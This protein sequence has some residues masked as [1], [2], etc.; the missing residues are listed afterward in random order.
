MLFLRILQ[1]LLPRAIAW[2]VTVAKTL[3]S[4]FEGLAQQ[5][6]A[7][8]TFLDLVWLDI[9]PSTTRSVNEWERHFGLPLSNESTDPDFVEARARLAAEWQ[10]TGGQSPAY[11]EGVLHAAGFTDLYVHEWWVSGPPYVARDPRDYTT[12]PRVGTYRCGSE[13]NPN[14]GDYVD[15]PTCT[16]GTGGPR[17]NNF[18]T[19]DPGYLVNKDLTQRPP[20]PVPD[21]PNTWPYF[22]Y[23]GGEVL[24]D[25]PVSVDP[26]RRDE[27]ERLLLKLRPTH[28]WIVLYASFAGESQTATVT[29]NTP[30]ELVATGSDNLYVPVTAE[31]FGFSTVI[32]G[33]NLAAGDNAEVVYSAPDPGGSDPVAHV[34]VTIASQ[35]YVDPTSV[36]VDMALAADAS[37]SGSSIGQPSAPGEVTA[38][39]VNP[40]VETV[41]VEYEFDVYSGDVVTFQPI[42]RAGGTYGG[43][44]ELRALTMIV[45]VVEL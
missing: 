6:A 34:T 35:W 36:T 37:G 23:I 16:D 39:L 11:I 45:T 3:R 18:L 24:D 4:F 32:D 33:A 43:N 42:A 1:H 31:N 17:C 9:F 7:I 44:I 21:D 25:G 29:L 19:N 26:A 30:G 14:G 8:K 20:P 15:G 40:T 2:R 22:V 5:P 41:D 28:N 38:T 10:A 27:L 12:Q 13:A